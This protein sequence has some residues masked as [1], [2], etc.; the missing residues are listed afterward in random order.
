MGV[1]QPSRAA[2]R[3]PR[4]R[5]RASAAARSR[6]ASRDRLLASAKALFAERGLHGVTTHDIAEHAGLA[7]GTFYLHF[8]D[9]RAIFREI[10]LETVGQLRS[11]V[12]A[13]TAGAAGLDASVRAQAEALVGFAEANRD[14]MQ[15][16]F[17]ADADAS[18]IESDV[19]DWL[20]ASIEARRRQR[21]AANDLEPE[22]D[23]V[24]LSQ[25][26][27]GMW[28]RVIAW[29]LR[30]PRR[31]PRER[32]VRTLTRIQLSGTQPGAQSPNP[33]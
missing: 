28:A 7:A 16:L 27:V 17:S 19:L 22:L 2:R 13:A 3:L 4:P 6:A 24:V 15:I 26:I 30:D 31:A 21:A 11:C 5:P 20:A 10:A 32:I 12:D 1:T 33:Q 9:K 18:A 23:P 8:E 29:W 14:V 25:A